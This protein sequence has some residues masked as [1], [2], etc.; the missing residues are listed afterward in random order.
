MSIIENIKRII[1]DIPKNI[2]IVAATKTRS[3]EE[4]KETIEAGIKII[5]ENYVQEAESKYKILEG[6]VEMHCIG[7]LQSNK[8]KK[9][10]EIFDMIQTVDSEKLA[11]EI[12]KRCSDIRKI[13]DVLIE[14]NIGDEERKKGCLVSDV[15]KLASF[16]ANLD[17]L[18]LK[19]IMTMGPSTGGEELRPYFRKVK[20]LFDELREDYN[21]DTLSMGMS[22]SYKVAIE[23]GATMVRL[24]TLILGNRK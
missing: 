12:D 11:K 20:R 2:V 21:L 14:V 10:V 22:N 9:A 18:N 3:I 15:P 16:I 6:N 1:E 23:E 4:I 8:V 19:G 5:G 7:H 17:N 13:M 24:G